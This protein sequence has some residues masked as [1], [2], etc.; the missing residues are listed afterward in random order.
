[1]PIDAAATSLPAE[2]AEVA[3]GRS[4]AHADDDDAR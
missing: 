1:M 4:A 3:A 2:R